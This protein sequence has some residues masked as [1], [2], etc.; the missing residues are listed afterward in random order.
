MRTF[1]DNA[2]ARRGLLRSPIPTPSPE[3]GSRPTARF[4]AALLPWTWATAFF[5]LYATVAVRRHLLLRTTGYDLGIFEQAV[6]AYS[7]LRPPVVPLRGDHFNLL[8][9]H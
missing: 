1:S 4:P 3:P 8:G 6:R 5:L 2:V 7:Q 9:D